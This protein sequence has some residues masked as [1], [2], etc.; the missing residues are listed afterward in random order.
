M[1]IVEIDHELDTC[2]LH[3]PEPVMMLHNKISNMT[4]GEVVRMVATDPSTRRDIVNFCGYLDHE[5]LE[6]SQKNKRYYYV[7]RKISS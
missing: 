2:G 6:H 5:L 7:I 4:S 3:C 1:N